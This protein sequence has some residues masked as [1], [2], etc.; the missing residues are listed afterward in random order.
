MVVVSNFDQQ[1]THSFKLV[2]PH[3]VISQWQLSDGSYP[4][5]DQLYG[6]QATLVVADGVGL[7]EVSIEALG[8]LI[9]QLHRCIGA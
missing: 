6:N 5:T 7:I 2:V 4:L 3:K 9:Y 8:S 1:Q